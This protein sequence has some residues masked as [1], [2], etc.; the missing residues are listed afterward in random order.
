MGHWALGIG[1]FCRLFFYIAVGLVVY[2]QLI[3]RILPTE[4]LTIFNCE[5]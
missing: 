4:D 5:L 1:N 2:T 3:V